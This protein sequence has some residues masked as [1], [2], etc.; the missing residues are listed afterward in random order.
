VTD[1]PTWVLLVLRLALGNQY[2]RG[3]PKGDNHIAG[4]A[5]NWSESD[6]YIITFP[7]EYFLHFPLMSNLT[8]L[9][10]PPPESENPPPLGLSLWRPFFFPFTAY[11]RR[12]RFHFISENIG[13]IAQPA[14]TNQVQMPQF[15]LL[16][17]PPPVPIHQPDPPALPRWRRLAEDHRIQSFCFIHSN[18]IHLAE[19]D[20]P[21][22][23]SPKRRRLNQPL[24][25]PLSHPYC[26]ATDPLQAVIIIHRKSI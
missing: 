12:Q 1:K 20:Q 16:R 3:T 18:I 15:H 6:T 13:V 23:R 5:Q 26:Q 7:L 21:T 17:F 11:W 4:K 24:F 9:H 14:P 19:P 2:T 8:D 25:P 22:E 10:F